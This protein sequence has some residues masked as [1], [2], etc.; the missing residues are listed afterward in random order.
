MKSELRNSHF[1]FDDV[2]NN[3]FVTTSQNSFRDR[4]GMPTVM[5]ENAKRNLRSTHYSLGKEMGKYSTEYYT[6]YTKKDLQPSVNMRELSNELR[7]THFK[8]G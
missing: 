5:D 4:G 3:N 2:K 7:S 8:L 1:K 6:K